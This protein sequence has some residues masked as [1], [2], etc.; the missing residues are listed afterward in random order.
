MIMPNHIV[1]VPLKFK[2]RKNAKRFLTMNSMMRTFYQ[3]K[4]EEENIIH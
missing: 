2:R 3:K 1:G 4:K